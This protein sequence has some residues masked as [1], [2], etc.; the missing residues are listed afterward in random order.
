[1]LGAVEP[2]E[3]AS[4]ARDAERAGLDAVFAADHLAAV[5]PRL[6]SVVTLATAAAATGRVRIGFGVMV[7]ALHGAAWA[8]RQVA[9][10]Q[11][12]SGGRV[13]L[14]V[15]SGGAAHGTAA[16]E[17]IGVPFA[18]RGRLTDEAL[19]V[20]PDLIAGR[21]ARMPSGVEL[22]L[23]PG[24]PVP[25]IWIGGGTGVAL[26]RC[27]EHGTAWFPSLVPA[28]Q[29]ASGARRLRELAAA[30]GRPAPAI[31][32][33]G[34]VLLGPAVSASLLGRFAA[35][36]ARYGLTPARA[37]ELPI[38]G[39]PAQAAVRF[40]EYAEAGAEHLVLGVI[41]G[42]WRQQCELIAEA[43]ARVG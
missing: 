42:D 25:P 31:A 30:H 13:I 24:A 22:T 36:L 43:R 32:V 2:G 40:A 34:S 19:T 5:E 10:L 6:D 38:T 39:S 27:V 9:S 11:L 35:G 7:L 23:A 33:G 17:A 4:R 37:A 15:G 41:G 8:A 1:M 3:V 12:V 28:R 21:P 20:L 14:G 29:V 18:E 26:R 16:W